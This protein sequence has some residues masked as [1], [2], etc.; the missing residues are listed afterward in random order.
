MH[1]EDQLIPELILH[2]GFAA[3]DIYQSV[4][5]QKKYTE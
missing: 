4:L 5:A 1:R 3:L 2:N